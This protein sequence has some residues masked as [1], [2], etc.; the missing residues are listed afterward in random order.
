MR[1]SGAGRLL[2]QEPLPFPVQD[3]G[4]EEQGPQAPGPV[5][6]R[7]GAGGG[8]QRLCGQAIQVQQIRPGAEKLRGHDRNPGMAHLPDEGPGRGGGGAEAW[9]QDCRSGC[10]ILG[11]WERD[12]MPPSPAPAPRPPLLPAGLVFQ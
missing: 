12:Q 10:E 2:Q 6:L 4:G 3:G 5:W 7:C 8:P 11:A 1:S 9:G